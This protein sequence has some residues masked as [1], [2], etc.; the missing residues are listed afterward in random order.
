MPKMRK[1]SEAVAVPGRKPFAGAL[2]R[3]TYQATRERQFK[4]LKAHGFGDLNQALLNVLVYPHPDGVRPSDWAERTY[5][6]K[7]AMNYLLGQLE[8]LGYI[9][10]RAEPGRRRRLVYLTRRGW[11]VIDAS[12][13]A[14]QE[15]ESEWA[16]VVGQKRFDEFMAVLRQLASI[17][18]N[19][20]LIGVARQ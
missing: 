19:G 6:T 2:L 18:A 10:R 13:K 3:M 14:V 15:L 1:S 17:S 4:M 11:Q 8:S 20:P 16:G 12:R 9:E 7:Q 5:M